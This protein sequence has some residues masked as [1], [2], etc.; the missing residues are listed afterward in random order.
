MEGWR[1]GYFVCAKFMGWTGGRGGRE[2]LPTTTTELGFMRIGFG[3]VVAVF[4]G[5]SVLSG[6]G[7]FLMVAGRS[8]GRRGWGLNKIFRQI[9]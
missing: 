8:G 4:T 7:A 6:L 2:S 9:N 1:R 5:P 3:A